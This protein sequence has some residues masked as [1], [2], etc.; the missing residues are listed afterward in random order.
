[1]EN[2]TKAAAKWRCAFDPSMTTPMR[3]DEINHQQLYYYIKDVVARSLNPEDHVSFDIK[4]E[5]I[6]KTR[7]L[8]E[9]YCHVPDKPE[10]KDGETECKRLYQYYDANCNIWRTEWIDASYD[11]LHWFKLTIEKFDYDK[12][13]LDHTGN[14]T[15]INPKPVFFLA[16]TEEEAKALFLLKENAIEDEL[17]NGWLSIESIIRTYGY[18]SGWPLIVAEEC[19]AFAGDPEKELW[20]KKQLGYYDSSMGLADPTSLWVK[21]DGN[22]GWLI[23]EA[24]DWVLDVYYKFS[25]DDEDE[26]CSQANQFFRFDDEHFRKAGLIPYEEKFGESDVHTFWQDGEGYHVYLES[27]DNLVNKGVLKLYKKGKW[28]MHALS[29]E[30]AEDKFLA[31]QLVKCYHERK[32]SKDVSVISMHQ[33]FADFFLER[34]NLALEEISEE[35]A[36]GCFC[37]DIPK[38][39]ILDRIINRETTR[40]NILV[41]VA[42]GNIVVRRHVFSMMNQMRCYILEGENSNLLLGTGLNPL[43]AAGELALDSDKEE[44]NVEVKTLGEKG[45]V[46]YVIP[47]FSRKT[48]SISPYKVG[49]I[50]P[51]SVP[52]DSMVMYW[53]FYA[54]KTEDE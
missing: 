32:Y 39:F 40:K 30:D 49:Y 52:Y 34:D 13:S 24:Y 18:D 46:E 44:I 48:I 29:S 8:C 20:C 6:S 1:M 22:S 45:F 19:D 15:I 41:S 17:V 43:D 2:I 47:F 36:E 37:I 53:R 14:Y 21:D 50:V 51:Y 54:P 42:C 4:D 11:D 27:F 28:I 23:K 31:Y 12:Q 25:D 26:F 10:K 38:D 9:A 35:D 33:E 5:T 7:L 3:V 16:G